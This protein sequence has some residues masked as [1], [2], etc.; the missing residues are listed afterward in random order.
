MA[1]K[2]VL[3]VFGTYLFVQLFDFDFM[4]KLLASAIQGA[5]SVAFQIL[6]GKSD[7]I[8]IADLNQI[9]DNALVRQTS[10]DE[11]LLPK[12]LRVMNN[13][14]TAI[15]VGIVAAVSASIQ[16]NFSPT[17]SETFSKTLEGVYPDRILA[18]TI[19]DQF[20]Q[21]KSYDRG[22]VKS[23]TDY[24][25]STVGFAVLSGLG[26]AL[27]PSLQKPFK[28]IFSRLF[29]LRQISEL[30]ENGI[31]VE[32]GQQAIG[33]NFARRLA[34][35]FGYLISGWIAG[36]YLA[37]A[38]D[39][40][41]NSLQAF[42]IK[43]GTSIGGAFVADYLNALG[44][45]LLSR[46]SQT[47]TLAFTA[48][49]A[50]SISF[51]I[52]AV[53]LGKLVTTYLTDYYSGPGSEIF[54]NNP[55][56]VFVATTIATALGAGFMDAILASGPGKKVLSA[57]NSALTLAFGS[58]FSKRLL[59]TSI[60]TV[61]YIFAGFV[62]YSFAQQLKKNL[63]IADNSL[64]GW[65]ITIAS[66]LSSI[67]LIPFIEA[68]SLWAYSFVSAL[69]VKIFAS[70]AKV[71][72]KVG[73]IIFGKSAFKVLLGK[74]LG[75]TFAGAGIG[76]LIGVAIDE[77][78]RR[79]GNG[80]SVEASQNLVTNS[81]I[82][83]GIAAFLAFSLGRSLK[84][85]IPI[86]TSLLS[87]GGWKIA[88]PIGL[89]ILQGVTQSLNDT[90]F[91][92]AYLG[93]GDTIGRLLDTVINTTLFALGSKIVFGG[94]KFK[95]IGT[96]IMG[97]IVFGMQ[98]FKISDS[99]ALSY[100]AAALT[101]AVTGAFLTKSPWGALGG[102]IVGL[103]LKGMKDFPELEAKV[104]EW[105]NTIR[106]AITKL[107]ETIF[108]EEWWVKVIIGEIDLFDTGVKAFKSFMEGV[109]SVGY[110]FYEYI[111]EIFTID[112]SAIA[113]EF[114]KN[115]TESGGS[116]SA[117]LLET[118]KTVADKTIDWAVAP[119]TTSFWLEKLGLNDLSVAVESQSNAFWANVWR[120]IVDSATFITSP[121]TTQY[122]LR[123]FN[124]DEA[125]AELDAQSKKF[126][127]DFGYGFTSTLDLIIDKVLKLSSITN[128]ITIPKNTNPYFS[129]SDF[130]PPIKKASGGYISGPGTGTSDSIL[131]RLSDGEYV[132]NSKSTKRFRPLLDKINGYRNGG[133]VGYATGGKV[134]TPAAGNFDYGAPTSETLDKLTQGKFFD[135][136][137]KAWKDS[138]VGQY[139]EETAQSIM[140]LGDSASKAAST[141]NGLTSAA[142]GLSD[143]ENKAIESLKNR[144]EQLEE[145]FK[146]ITFTDS[147]SFKEKGV[148][149]AQSMR[150]SFNSSISDFLKGKSSFKNMI[151]SILDTFTSGIIDA[152]VDTFTK[153]MFKKLGLDKVFANI[154]ESISASGANAGGGIPLGGGF[155][156]S[157]IFSSIF[158][159]I[160]NFFNSIFTGFFSFLSFASGGLVRGPGSGTS[161]SIL[162]ALS[163]GEY[164][165]NAQAAKQFKPILDAMNY[166]K[167]IPAFAK[168]GQVG[169]GKNSSIMR[170]IPSRSESSQQ[171]VINITGDVSSQT[172]QEI[173]RMLPE[174]ATGVNIVNKERG[175]R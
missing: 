143:S 132:I 114:E 140:G 40:E 91:V 93:K 165:V 109:K 47:K 174:I 18:K 71:G 104:E 105:L 69:R 172:R 162:A 81:A 92:E 6:L 125:A 113:K 20:N 7:T 52:P 11:T 156:L 137:A 126:W 82:V 169:I 27:V 112:F 86:V 55:G 61:S 70:F 84:R 73:A 53:V 33:Q 48:R 144:R 80:L 72:Q 90:G 9:L 16:A 141:T 3:A 12:T 127:S 161:D 15:G 158:S 148:E 62:G 68:L 123:L 136:L 13:I 2:G 111:K 160:G 94:G 43:A 85:A 4:S 128:Q 14:G 138:N 147:L 78:L 119:F 38:L 60:L 45:G 31:K 41:S 103:L 96:L 151:G 17:L 121:F 145:A 129:S 10:P 117:A 168:G 133:L 24:L 163:N 135:G 146:N 30:L 26:L 46:K 102:A 150:D 63:G 51:L 35:N 88:L 42:L 66:I 32:K 79:T 8:P 149:F 57:V 19:T 154:G 166:N 124:F 175:S 115:K 21:G 110:E 49:I 100:A 118:S 56:I 159:G 120:G 67:L 65:S 153:S 101:S 167:K 23:I 50:K 5:I 22:L 36:G 107:K 54:K 97:S 155:D 37:D 170:N 130:L 98:A 58:N 108:S 77:T 64:A 139:L 83:G 25:G 164:V 74:M 29:G 116:N 1:S 75:V 59:R 131:A 95:I 173:A 76:F 122:W 99:P 44:A 157:K 39:Y 142:K 171:F 28:K 152:F 89:V 34:R 106:N 87:S 134:N